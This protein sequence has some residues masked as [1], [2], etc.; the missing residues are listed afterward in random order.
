MGRLCKIGL[1]GVLLVAGCGAGSSG[2]EP[3]GTELVKLACNDVVA[4]AHAP[5]GTLTTSDIQG[6]INRATGHADNAVLLDTRWQAFDND[7]R[8][9]RVAF[10]DNSGNSKTEE[11]AVSDSASICQGV[12]NGVY[13]PAGA[14]PSV[15]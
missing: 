3:G 2:S 12:D 13:P 1:L 7:L 11:A 6:Q 4:I 15:T 8:I 9:M 10:D 14:S 5:A